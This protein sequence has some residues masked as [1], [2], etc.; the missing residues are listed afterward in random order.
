MISLKYI[1]FQ[2][3]KSILESSYTHSKQISLQVHI[4][5]VGQCFEVWLLYRV[6]QKNL[7]GFLVKTEWYFP[8]LFLNSKKSC[9]STSFKKNIIS[10]H[11]AKKLLAWQFSQNCLSKKHLALKSLFSNKIILWIFLKLS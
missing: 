4:N 8:M 5:L 10:S 3:N 7:Q 9:I 6:L 11:L 2:V 1:G